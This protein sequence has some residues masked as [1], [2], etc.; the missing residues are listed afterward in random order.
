[1]V[2]LDE[3][4]TGLGD[5]YVLIKISRDVRFIEEIKEKAVNSDEFKLKA[6]GTA[7][8]LAVRLAM[9]AVEEQIPNFSIDNVEIGT[10]ENVEMRNNKVR[11][12]SWMEIA[13]KKN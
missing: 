11:P 1:M 10:E 2:L 7:I 12:L 4:G 9:E 6:W 8:N 13:L 5:E 3:L